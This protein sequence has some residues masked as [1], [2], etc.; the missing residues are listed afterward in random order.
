MSLSNS[1]SLATLP[2]GKLLTVMIKSSRH[3]EEKHADLEH[4]PL[5]TTVGRSDRL[6]FLVREGDKDL[7]SVRQECLSV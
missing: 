2:H 7:S 4:F 3:G 6:I 5:F 1:G